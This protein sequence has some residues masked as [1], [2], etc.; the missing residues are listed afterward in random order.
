[1]IKIIAIGNILLCD[2]GIGVKVIEAMR[3]TLLD[4]DEGVAVLIGETDFYYCLE[5]IEPED[6]LI[7]VDSTYLGI[8]P[9][10]ITVLAISECDKYVD[11]CVTEHG[12]SLVDVLRRE[13]RD[14]DGYLIGIEVAKIGFSLELS[15]VLQDEF[16]NIYLRVYGEIKS[17]ISEQ[18]K[19]S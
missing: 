9:G 2:D 3:K 19:I 4:I 13:C 6:F 17:I 15:S 12:D 8:V 18:L 16:Q 11:E 14:I 10:T 1:M 5:N 7:I